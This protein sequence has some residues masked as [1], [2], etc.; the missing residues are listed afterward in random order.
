MATSSAVTGASTAFESAD[1]CVYGTDHRGGGGRGMAGGPVDLGDQRQP[2]LQ[3][4]P[5]W[6]PWPAP[7]K[8]RD[9]L[10]FGC[11]RREAVEVAPAREV[12]Q[13]PYAAWWPWPRRSSQCRAS[14]VCRPSPPQGCPSRKI[15][16]RQGDLDCQYGGSARHSRSR[17]C[18]TDG[19]RT[20]GPYVGSSRLTTTG[21]GLELKCRRC[22]ADV[23]TGYT[24]LHEESIDCA[25]DR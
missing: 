10:G 13:S 6:R 9:G 22:A 5:A 12:G 2:P 14:P 18:C 11:Q 16:G 7:T 23:W 8:Y 3:R 4:W 17:R 24:C 21:T 20:H 15:D 19:S 25:Q 1:P